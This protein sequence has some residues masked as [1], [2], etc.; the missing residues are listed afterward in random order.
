MS[1]PSIKTNHEVI[2]SNGWV[3]QAENLT[4]VYQMGAVE[5]HALNGLSLRIARGEIVASWDLP[6][7]ENQP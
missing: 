3:I 1:D 6:V 7:R 2:P 5:V 4:K